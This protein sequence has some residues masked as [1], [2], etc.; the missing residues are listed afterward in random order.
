LIKTEAPAQDHKKQPPDPPATKNSH[1]RKTAT[2]DDA[3][4]ETHR[5]T[6][7]QYLHRKAQIWILGEGGLRKRKLCGQSGVL[8]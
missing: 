3:E 2:E 4:P 7:G 5:T 1:G 8:L 6:N